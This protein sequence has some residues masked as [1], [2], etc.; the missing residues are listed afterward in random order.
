VVIRR[1]TKNITDLQRDCNDEELF[2]LGKFL[3]LSFFVRTGIPAQLFAARCEA[4]GNIGP[5]Q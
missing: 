5:W 3:F 1:N 2:T 4:F